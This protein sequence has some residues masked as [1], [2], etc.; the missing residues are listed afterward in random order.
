MNLKIAAAVLSVTKVADVTAQD[1]RGQANEAEGERGNPR[2][3]AKPGQAPPGNPGGRTATDTPPLP[4]KDTAPAHSPR[5]LG[6]PRS[7]GEPGRG[8]SASSAGD[9]SKAAP[10]LGLSVQMCATT[11]R[12]SILSQVMKLGLGMFGMVSA[13][14]WAV[15]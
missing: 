5:R 7:L 1:L 9:D 15:S 11:S 10:A 4:Q 6:R 2:P 12:A 8:P 14:A 13:A 3:A